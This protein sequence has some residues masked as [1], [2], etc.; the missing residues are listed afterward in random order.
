MLLMLS[1]R[2][3]AVLHGNSQCAIAAAGDAVMQENSQQELLIRI[4]FS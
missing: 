3:H 2:P 1:S 4:L